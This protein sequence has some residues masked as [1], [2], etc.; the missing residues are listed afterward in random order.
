M[1]E[2]RFTVPPALRVLGWVLFFGLL[3]GML[4]CVTA[5]AIIGKWFVT[6]RALPDLPEPAK[7]LAGATPGTVDVQTQPG[8]FLRCTLDAGEKCWVPVDVPMTETDPGCRTYPI[9]SLFKDAVDRRLVCENYADGGYTVQYILRRDGKV[10]VWRASD[11]GYE[12]L[13]LFLFPAVCAPLG[14][15]AGLVIG[16]VRNRKRAAI[17]TR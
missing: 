11:S 14:L 13:L 17:I 9:A 2:T 6:W 3:G 8:R 5:Y 12:Q 15:A 16:L 4:S 7:S 1:T 10:Y